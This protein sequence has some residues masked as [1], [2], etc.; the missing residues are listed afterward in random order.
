MGVCRGCSVKDH[1]LP[2]T[3]EILAALESPTST[4][5]DRRTPPP[6]TQGEEKV[7][8]LPNTLTKP[9]LATKVSEE[10]V[11][12]AHLPFYHVLL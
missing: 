6:N 7:F 2:R 4:H 12:A 8:S 5:M 3:C 10:C 9:L 1:L 11:K